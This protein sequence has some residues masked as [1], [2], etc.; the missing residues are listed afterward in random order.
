MVKSWKRIVLKIQT[1]L[2]LKIFV[3][4]IQKNGLKNLSVK[5]LKKIC[6]K[7]FY[8]STNSTLPF[9]SAVCMSFPQVWIAPSSTCLWF[10]FCVGTILWS[11]CGNFI[12]KE[13]VSRTIAWIV[14]FAKTPFFKDCLLFY[15]KFGNIVIFR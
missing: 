1:K 14:P 4:K 11:V 10:K 8:T 9:S 3:W 6:L 2:V 7:K 12:I 15:H 13:G 5:K